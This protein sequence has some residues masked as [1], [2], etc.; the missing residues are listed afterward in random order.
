MIISQECF[1]VRGRE[2]YEWYSP[3]AS[4]TTR[5]FNS[6]LR[7]HLF[8]KA[9]CIPSNLS[10]VGLNWSLCCRRQAGWRTDWL[11]LCDVICDDTVDLQKSMLL[12]LH[13][14]SF[15]CSLW[16]SIGEISTLHTPVPDP[17]TYESKHVLPNFSS[18]SSLLQMWVTFGCSDSFIHVTLSCCCNKFN[19]WPS[20]P[21]LITFDVC[22]SEWLN[23]RRSYSLLFMTR[24]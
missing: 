12:L 16:K 13:T 7:L 21:L 4:T 11:M 10:N 8:H 23:V 1:N 15:L 9:S 3:T 18:A 20:F 24:R 5:L 22:V 17:R 2:Q 19:N 6:L 14:C